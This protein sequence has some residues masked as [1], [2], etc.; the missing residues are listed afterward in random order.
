MEWSILS[1]PQLPGYWAGVAVGAAVV[2]AFLEAFL[3]FL[4]FFAVFLWCLTA[5][6]VAAGA[7]VVTAGMVVSGVPVGAGAV[8]SAL[9]AANADDA[10][11]ES[12]IMA[13]AR[14]VFFIV[15]D[16]L[17]FIMQEWSSCPRYYGRMRILW[18]GD[19]DCLT[20]IL[21]GVI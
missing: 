5:L 9:V 11:S 20:I 8:T 14:N 17:I 15:Y 6:V 10:V 1:F 19:R 21:K 2:F 16:E 3:A 13:I 18:Q 4:V 12:P 7:A